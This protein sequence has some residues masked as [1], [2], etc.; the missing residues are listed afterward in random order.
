MKSFLEYD[1]VKLYNICH[2]ADNLNWNFQMSYEEEMEQLKKWCKDN[3]ATY[4]A[5]PRETFSY[6]D[7]VKTAIQEGK[8]KCIVEDLS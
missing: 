5:A 2:L 7:A 3:N 6:Y 8:V 1:G 4:Y